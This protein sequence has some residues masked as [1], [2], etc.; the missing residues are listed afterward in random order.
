MQVLAIH[1]VVLFRQLD[2]SGTTRSQSQVGIAVVQLSQSKE[3]QIVQRNYGCCSFFFLLMVLVLA[4][5]LVTFV[6][7]VTFARKAS[8]LQW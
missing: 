6:T 4:C 1:P 5:A 7:F 3:R 2:T 8:R